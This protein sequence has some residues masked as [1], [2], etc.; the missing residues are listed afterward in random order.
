MLWYVMFGMKLDDHYWIFGKGIIRVIVDR[1]VI[2]DICLCIGVTISRLG[3]RMMGY[4]YY[5]SMQHKEDNKVNKQPK[6]EARMKKG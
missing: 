2:V 3:E 6:E 5:R 1:Y 4:L